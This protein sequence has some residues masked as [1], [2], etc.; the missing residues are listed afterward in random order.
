MGDEDDEPG[1]VS[2]GDGGGGPTTVLALFAVSPP[3][4]QQGGGGASIT[5]LATLPA[6]VVTSLPSS[7]L[8]EEEDTPD[9]VPTHL[10]ERLKRC[11]HMD[12]EQDYRLPA[13]DVV[14]SWI[15][16]LR[17]SDRDNYGRCVRYAKIHR[18]S[19]HLTAY[20][21]YLMSITEQYNSASSVT[22]K[23]SYVQGCIFLSFPVI[24]NN[25]Q[26]TGYKYDWSNIV[27][28]K[29]SSAE[30][31]FLLC[32][33]SESPVILQ[34]LITKGG[35]CS[36]MV[37]Y[38]EETT[39][40]CQN[41][42]IGFLHTQLVMVPFVP[43]A[44]PNYAVPFLSLS[45]DARG[46]AGVEDAPFGQ[47][48]ITRHGPALL[49]RVE[50]LTWAGKRVTTYG[51][52]R[53][54]RY[55]SQFRGTME[56]EEAELP[57]E[58]DVWVSSKNVQYEFMG[59]VF[60]VNVDTVCV[61]AENRQLLGTI[62]TSYCHRVSDKITARNMPRGFCFYLLTD[63]HKSRDLQ[64]S[65]N[66]GLFFSG[67]ALNCTLLNEPNLF[68]LT[69]HAPYD[70]HFNHQPRQTVE[71]DVRYV[72][73]TE[74]CFLVAN[75]PHEDAFYTGLTVW[76]GA[77]PLKVTLWARARA[78]VVP[79]GTPIATLYQISDSNGNLYS[80]NHNTVFRQV[81]STSSTVFFLGDFK[82]PTDNFLTT[83]RT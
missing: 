59:L 75:L 24:Y 56:D 26:G 10:A 7:T 15:E 16:A 36:S 60:T 23:A 40:N 2:D 34:P 66:P 38:D 67:D 25:S 63:D 45:K 28:P 49:C 74:R 19:Y 1:L 4:T 83:P 65:R 29:S 27:T 53:I 3:P 77:E 20:E 44:Y 72:Q 39:K 22:E 13:R 69:V 51:H 35:L 47:A 37:V 57:G 55:I 81:R 42:H 11:R 58:H 68:S 30:L 12:P 48:V 64:F 70:I 46:L 9:G 50:H 14:D 18:S 78:T 33:T 80:Y 5:T 31:F 76:R 17:T 41:V 43:H 21:H 32:S 79:Q 71:I 62:S 54:T 61:D 8:P 6:V 73:T 52:K 82:L